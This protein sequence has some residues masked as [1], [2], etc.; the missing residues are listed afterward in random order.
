MEMYVVIILALIIFSCS[1]YF[2]TVEAGN[3]VRNEVNR[4]VN[5][6]NLN[7]AEEINDV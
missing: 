6:E 7:P 2:D 5:F 4:N 1:R 3:H